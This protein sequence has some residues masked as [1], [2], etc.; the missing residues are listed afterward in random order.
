MLRPPQPSDR[1]TRTFT[2]HYLLPQGVRTPGRRDHWAA[3]IPGCAELPI[4]DGAILIGHKPKAA[5]IG[6]SARVLSVQ[7][8]EADQVPATSRSVIPG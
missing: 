2:H 6:G 3:G 7:V 4:M 8:A 5:R 1:I